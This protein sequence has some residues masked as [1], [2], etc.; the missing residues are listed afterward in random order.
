MRHAA[1]GFDNPCLWLE[2]LHQD[3]SKVLGDFDVHAFHAPA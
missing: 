3:L 2:G 1:E